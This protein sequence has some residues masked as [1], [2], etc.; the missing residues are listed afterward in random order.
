[1]NGKSHIFWEGKTN[2]RKSYQNLQCISCKI[3]TSVRDKSRRHWKN[4]FQPFLNFLHF[5][6]VVL[7]CYFVMFTSSSISLLLVAVL[8][9]YLI[10]LFYSD[11]KNYIFSI[12]IGVWH[13]SG[14][15]ILYLNKHFSAD[16]ETLIILMYTITF[17]CI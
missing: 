5:Y 13:D 3:K 2:L 8:V 15:G 1:M 4:T 12:V 7:F 16:N 11:N 17:I 14:C 6:F 10:C 9:C